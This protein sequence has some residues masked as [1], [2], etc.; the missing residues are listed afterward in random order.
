M[1]IPWIGMFVGAVASWFAM[2]C[3]DDPEDDQWPDPV[4]FALA[5]DCGGGLGDA[6][7]GDGGD[8]RDD[9]GSPFVADMAYAEGGGFGY[10]G[11]EPS[12]EWFP[13][14]VGATPFTAAY[15]VRRDGHTAYRVDVP[16]EGPYVVT[17]GFSER[18][19]HGPGLRIQDV[20]AEGAVIA[21]ELDV[22][23]EAG[24]DLAWQV[25]RDVVVTDGVLDITFAAQ[26]ELP[27]SLATLAVQRL[28]PDEDIPPAPERVEAIDSY[29]SVVVRWTPV[30]GDP[31]YGWDPVASEDGGL[32]DGATPFGDVAG[33]QVER[34]LQGGGEGFTALF[35]GSRPVPFYVDRDVDVGQRYEYRVRVVDVWGNLGAASGVGVGEA[36]ALSD[37][38]LPL[39]EIEIADEDL[40]TLQ[41]DPW[42]DEEVDLLVRYDGEE[43]AGDGRFRGASTRGLAKKS[44]RLELDDAL[45]DG[46]HKLDLKSEWGDW[47]QVS[48]LLSYDMLWAEG[49][50]DPLEV[51]AGYATPVQLVING[52]YDG[53]RLDVERMD[54]DFLRASGRAV[55]GDLYR[56]GG[57][58][59]LLDGAD[60]Y[61]EAYG[62][63][64]G[65]GDIEH[66]VAFVEYQN[67]A[68]RDE[69]A[70]ELPEVVDLDALLDLLAV[71]ALLARPETEA[72]DYFY[73]RDPV[74]ERWEVLTWDNNNG[75]FGLYNFVTGTWPYAPPVHMSL[76]YAESA[77]MSWWHLL[78]TR[79]LNHPLYREQLSARIADLTEQL[80]QTQT[81]RQQIHARFNELEDEIIGDPTKYPWAEHGPFD[82]AEDTLIE[83]VDLRLD[84]LLEA[85]DGLASMPDE[86]LVINEFGFE[87]CAEDGPCT[88]YGFI[89]LTNRGDA[90]VEFAG[91]HLTDDLRRPLSWPLPEGELAPGQ[92]LLLEAGA[93]GGDDMY[94]LDVDGGELGLFVSGGDDEG[95]FRAVDLWWYGRQTGGLS[96]GR[97]ADG[98]DAFGFLLVPTAGEANVGATTEAP[99]VDTMVLTPATPAPGEAFGVAV[100][101]VHPAG[102]GE[103]ICYWRAAGEQ[104]QLALLDDG[105]HGDGGA[106]DGLF[107]G[108][109]GQVPEAAS[110]VSLYIEAISADGVRQ[111]DPRTAP[112]RWRRVEFGTP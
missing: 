65:A 52:R 103:V 67:R 21:H 94:R 72:D 99:R 81:F 92:H 9:D 105:Q 63:R 84:A 4:D 57:F 28:N 88:P 42:A 97:V 14:V 111:V 31:G 6:D 39:V 8:D 45:P 90:P 46:R 29:E 73:Y 53:L 69:F 106:G 70:T 108:E 48:E 38:P 25:R 13:W 60:A 82:L 77:E 78:W 30:E 18:A 2:G 3:K 40:R 98:A 109:L 32:P 75:N 96:Y 49:G 35:G 47:T 95:G 50:G 102:V 85:L 41:A 26:G 5:I 86:P 80:L 11:G 91:Y 27:T 22:F 93:P 66:L 33:Y 68:H 79:L 44:W 58:G 55:D 20:S 71:Y 101:V 17:L 36:R 16:Q 37:S 87:P 61:A 100:S 76:W 7:D 107:G 104:G 89:E 112:G 110:E 1:R 83:A 10:E 23:E 12:S 54:A 15:L 24:M 59:E 74:E 56:G 43:R 51:Q 34:K 19:A 64:A 62:R